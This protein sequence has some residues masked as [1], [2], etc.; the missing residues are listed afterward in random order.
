MLLD[1]PL[2]RAIAC[3]LG[4]AP[5]AGCAEA[6]VHAPLD[7]EVT[8]SPL[9]AN[10]LT[11]T[12][13]TEI[14]G[15]SWVEWGEVGALDRE[16][17]H[18]GAGTEHAVTVLGIP[19]AGTVELRAVTETVDGARLES[20][21]QTLT[22]A[23]PEPPLPELTLEV[24]NDELGGYVLMNVGEPQHYT[25]L[26]V[27]RQGRP[28]WYADGGETALSTSSVIS[29]D[30]KA[31]LF[32]SYPL[33]ML[34]PSGSVRRRELDG[35]SESR[36]ETPGQH[37][38]FVELPDGSIAYLATRLGE[39]GGESIIGDGI[40]QSDGA[41]GSTER[42][43]AWNELEPYAMCNHFQPVLYADDN[44]DWVHANSLRYEEGEDTFLLMSRNL[45][46]LFAIDRQT[47]V[48]DWQLGGTDS[49]FPLPDGEG[50]DHAH[51]SD[52]WP[53]GFTVFDNGLHRSPHLSRVSEYAYDADARTATRV[54]S[55]D[56]DTF[57]DSLGDVKKLDAGY[58]ISWST[59]GLATQVDEAGATVW[60]VRAP[61]DFR[62]GHVTLV[63]DL[64]AP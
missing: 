35:S 2:L 47:G 46:A 37:H 33:Q 54:W 19:V 3:A 7:V 14:E 25:V 38:D 23:P 49:D 20:A 59:E 39:W 18:A 48:I 10:V 36:V 40:Y 11:V 1:A 15:T 42:F 26:I 32:N 51:F 52:A 29:R 9:L 31:V 22:L 13:E 61:A 8:A 5:L 30:G 24:P 55:F 50:F 62:I 28:V 53:D 43:S 27:D 57:D 63:E 44:W 6:D 34:E 45:D 58:L 56:R 41:G 21:T 64:Y 17:P 12:W 60:E 4:L 16:T